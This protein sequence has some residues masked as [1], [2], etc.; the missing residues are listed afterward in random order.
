MSID[1]LW[2]LHVE[3]TAVLGRR[4]SAE[5]RVLGQ[6]LQSSGPAAHR[7]RTNGVSDALTPRVFPKYRNPATATVTW[8][9]RGKQPHWLKAELQLGKR[10]KIL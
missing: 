5:E 3:I 10:L 1:E 2:A 9:G 8:A 6:R 4:I 7:T